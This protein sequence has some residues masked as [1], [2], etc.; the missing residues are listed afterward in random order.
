[1]RRKKCLGVLV[2]AILSISGVFA[3]G[4]LAGMTVSES[5]DGR[6]T[7]KE[8]ER[9]VLTYN[10]KDQPVPP[11]VT[12]I[13]AVPRGD[14]VHPIYG[15]DGE[16]LT[17]AYSP[18]HPHHRGIYWAWPE[19]TYQGETRDL[20]ALQGVFSRPVKMRRVE[21]GADSARIEAENVWK[22]NDK[23]EIVRETVLMTV[24]RTVEKQRVI[25]FRFTFEA[26]LG[27]VGLA[28]RG[29]TEYGG[30]NVRLSPR[31]N[32]KIITH[33]DPEGT[34]PR[35]AWGEVAG[36]AP[37]SKGQVGL[38]ILESMSNPGYPG[39]W[40]QYEYLPWL[41]PT[42]PTTGTVYTLQPGRPLTL[43][44][45]LAVH[46]GE[47]DEKQL[48]G[49]WQAYQENGRGR[50]GYLSGWTAQDERARLRELEQH[51]L[52]ADTT[53]R[54]LAEEGLLA[55]LNSNDSTTDIRRWACQQL[56]VAGGDR[57]AAVLGKLLGNEELFEMACYGL[58]LN[59][60][61]A[62]AKSLREAL[63]KLPATRKVAVINA[64]AS[65]R[66]ADSVDVLKSLLDESDTAISV[67]AMKA[68]GKIGS[69]KSARVLA[70]QEQKDSVVQ[71]RLECAGRLA[72]DGC[73]T[74]AEEIFRSVWQGASGVQYRSRALVGLAKSAPDQ[75]MSL[76]LEALKD[77]DVGI[78]RASATALRLIG[79]SEVPRGLIRILPDLPEDAQVMALGV[80]KDRGDPS[81]VPEIAAAL[82]TAPSAS[83]QV[84]AIDA[85][86]VLGNVDQVEE[87]LKLARAEGPVAEHARKAL[88]VLP[89]ES[90]G[91]VLQKMAEQGTS[92]SLPVLIDVI[93][94]R[95]DEGAEETLLNLARTA[96]P[97]NESAIYSALQRIA[98]E[99][100]LPALVNLFMD[101]NTKDIKAAG[102]AILAVCGRSSD[103]QSCVATVVERI[104]SAAPSVRQERLYLLPQLG[105]EKALAVLRENVKSD[106]PELR[107]EALRGLAQW[108]DAIVI[109]DLRAH[110]KSS[111]DS[112][113]NV[114]LV[115]GLVRLIPLSQA[116]ETEKAQQLAEVLFAGR[117][118]EERNAVIGAMR[119]LHNVE[120]VAALSK[121]LTDVQKKRLAA[122]AIATVVMPDESG[123]GLEGKL[124]RKALNDAIPFLTD[125]ELASRARACTETIGSENLVQGKPVT[126]SGAWQ[127]DCCPERAVDGIVTLDSFWSHPVPD[128]W[129]QV[130]LKQ[131]FQV[132]RIQLTTYWDGSRYYQYRIELSTKGKDWLTVVDQ[133]QNTTPSVPTGTMHTIKPTVA[134]YIR[135][136]MLK[137]SANPGQ[138][139]VEL[140]AFEAAEGTV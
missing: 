30:F 81:V 104:Q 86:A 70:R 94:A 21:E 31:E 59:P 43:S 22:W 42:F 137:N 84:A 17:L 8:N 52:S 113:E 29:Q 103:R 91:S 18:D 48:A 77:P 121:R 118:D 50:Y 35:R 138:H 83:F 114:L 98:E 3:S 56:A 134:R 139:I 68:L 96:K 15:P 7:F 38:T 115:R 10:F 73:R 116:T 140:K 5:E 130:D 71:A 53:Q 111:P 24:F 14:Y 58:S 27:E 101:G 64:L 112:V 136:Q 131:E 11:G 80:L 99:K 100:H 46:S 45:R 126:S 109:P 16:E 89:G 4:A 90:T 44:Y 12:G 2:I 61:A 76:S 79:N 105:G 87:L 110:L 72:G 41:Q 19:V 75:A 47:L 117:R 26:L 93:A 120:T 127:G 6:F 39:D 85:L 51:F 40:V 97:E 65:R 66:D 132:D 95:Q 69:E 133:S 78:R 125:K 55:L 67:A 60:S 119:T 49:M 128:G 82:Q 135:V 92:G 129:L 63:P 9:P 37:G 32:L 34:I 74:Q 88:C 25:D 28:R 23:E 107:L 122:Q 106:A 36:V 1:M 124:A 123:T 102:R 33:T 13:Y 57:S 108:P 20:H 54:A 62:A